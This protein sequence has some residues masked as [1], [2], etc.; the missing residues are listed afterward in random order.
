MM[1]HWS[2]GRKIGA[3]FGV[4]LVL[5]AGVAAWSLLGIGGI[6]DNAGE[7]IAG[8]RAEGP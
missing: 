2:L 6:V 7:V 8:N 1:S 4:V 5:L 3:G